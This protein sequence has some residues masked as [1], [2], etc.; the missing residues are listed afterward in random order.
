MEKRGEMKRQ[1]IFPQV[2][3]FKVF[4]LAF[5]ILPSKR[6]CKWIKNKE[7]LWEGLCIHGQETEPCVFPASSAQP[8]GKEHQNL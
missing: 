3:S 6:K 4:E 2:C 8:G 7:L 5:M 1:I